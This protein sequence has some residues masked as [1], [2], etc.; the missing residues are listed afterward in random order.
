MVWSV[1]QAIVI[2]A[3]VFD[4][5]RDTG[6]IFQH[7]FTGQSRVTAGAAGRDNEPLASAERIEDRLKRFCWRSSTWDVS[8]DGRG[9]RLRLLVDFAQH[10]VR[11]DCGLGCDRSQFS[12]A[13]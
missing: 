3:G 1:C 4:V 5:D 6:E 9:K 11:E 12:H 7:D 13:L 2:S 10:G 8:L